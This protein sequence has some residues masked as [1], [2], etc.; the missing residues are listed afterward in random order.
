MHLARSELDGLAGSRE[1]L[2]AVPER[3]S[4]PPLVDGD[5]LGLEVVNVHWWACAW[6]HFAADVQVVAPVWVRS[7]AGEGQPFTDAVV[8]R[9]WIAFWHLWVSSL[10]SA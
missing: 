6:G 1:L 10:R 9:S 2:G 4:D 3:I 7:E 8:D 5:R